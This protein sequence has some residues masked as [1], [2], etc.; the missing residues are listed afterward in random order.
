MIKRALS[1]ADWD[2]IHARQ[3]R[4]F[5]VLG[6]LRS[7]VVMPVDLME[8]ITAQMELGDIQSLWL[9]RHISRARDEEG[10]DHYIYRKK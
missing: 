1:M 9:Y 6:I 4:E 10:N 2:Q 7:C 3:Q 5:A 8:S